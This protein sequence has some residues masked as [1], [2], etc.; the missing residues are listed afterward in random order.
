MAR[1]PGVTVAC[2]LLVC[3]GVLRAGAEEPRPKKRFVMPASFQMEVPNVPAPTMG[4]NQLW[5][6]EFYFGKWRIQRNV[7]TDHHR[8]LDPHDLR[9]ESGTFAECQQKLE[10]LKKDKSLQPTRGKVIVMLHGLMGSRLI[11]IPL[12]RHLE[13]EGG[14][15]VLSMTY[16][17]T[18]AGVAEHA[19][20][21]AAVMDSLDEA[22][23]IN[24]VAHSM[25]NLVVRH[26]LA[27]LESDAKEIDP[28]IKRF[29]MIGPP[30]HGARM[31]VMLG[32]NPIFDNTLGMSAQQLGRRWEELAPRLATPDFEFGIIA[33]GKGNNSGITPLL[34]GDD[35]GTVRVAEAR[36]VGASD[37]TLV[38]MHHLLLTVSPSVMDRT[39]RFLKEGRFLAE[40]KPRPITDEA[41]PP[42][43]TAKT[44]RTKTR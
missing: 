33:G 29:V 4:G 24:F 9:Y 11:M 42:T 30:N 27:D 28:R 44:E 10:V 2:L 12:A 25:G 17:S 26:Y 21:L 32:G 14:Y 3:C 20:S 43:E 31:A 23:E 6:D 35:D 13:R 5:E 39:L 19:Q 36:L 22:T 37:F 34:A 18:R 41:P 1:L 15:T 40:S 7:L 38:D 8:L 16:A